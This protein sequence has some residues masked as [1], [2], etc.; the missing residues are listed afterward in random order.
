MWV[1]VGTRPECIKQAPVYKAMAGRRPG[2]VHLIGTG[3]HHELLDDALKVLDVQLEDGFETMKPGQ[4]L[5]DLMARIMSEFVKL[6][7]RIGAPCSVIVQGDTTTAAAVAVAAFQLGIEVIHNEA[8]LRTHDLVNPFPEEANRRLISTV[9]SM[10][11]APTHL[12]K[13]NLEK[14]G[15]HVSQIHVV[16]N[17]GIDSLFWAL[18][19]D[20][21]QAEWIKKS[22]GSSDYRT[23]LLTA[24]RREAAGRP[25]ES[26]FDGLADYRQAN[27][28]YRFI[29]PTHPN[30]LGSIAAQR[31]A[32]DFPDQLVLRPPL[33]YVSLVHLMKGC[34]LILTDSGGIQEEAATLGIPTVVCRE[35]TE[36]QEAV[37]LGISVLAGLDRDRVGRSL[38]WAATRRSETADW[39]HRPYG[40]GAAAATIAALVLGRISAAS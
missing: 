25:F 7:D 24:H 15:V 19:Q 28:D 4:T 40:D 33:D 16:G 37:D 20:P 11:L 3:Q 21:N 18:K 22:T 32:A 39:T 23:C 34:E 5:P 1:V 8:G 6:V 10:H 12:A 36:R 9:A 13:A 30:E 27:R 31:V 38:S 26:L 17:T 35:K 2:R 29:Y 14:E